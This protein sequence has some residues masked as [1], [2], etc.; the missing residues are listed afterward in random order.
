MYVREW[1]RLTEKSPTNPFPAK[2]LSLIERRLLCFS[3]EYECRNLT[4]KLC[5]K[6]SPFVEIQHKGGL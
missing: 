4:K 5:R 3:D 2:R 6:L 1:S